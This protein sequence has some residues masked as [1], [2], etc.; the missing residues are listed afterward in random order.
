MIFEDGFVIDCRALLLLSPNGDR[1]REVPLPAIVRDLGSAFMFSCSPNG[2][3]DRAIVRDLGSA[4]FMFSCL[5]KGDRDRAIVRDLGS[6]LFT[7]HAGA[8]VR[9][10]TRRA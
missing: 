3:R 1:D 10:Y 9:K 8:F 2:D 6:A 5:P 4:L 7:W